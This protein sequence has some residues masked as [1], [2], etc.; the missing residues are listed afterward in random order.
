MEPDFRSLDQD[1]DRAIDVAKGVGG[2]FYLQTN[3]PDGHMASRI[4]MHPHMA[5]KLR[6]WLIEKYPALVPDERD[7]HRASDDGMP[8][9]SEAGV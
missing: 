7:L 6:D 8:D 5:Q 1:F 2:T 9:P 3:S 4:W